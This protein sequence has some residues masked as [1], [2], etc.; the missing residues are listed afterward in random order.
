MG[1][2]YQ[3]CLVLKMTVRLSFL[4]YLSRRTL[5]HHLAS[6]RGLLLLTTLASTLTSTLAT[7]SSA[8]VGARAPSCSGPVKSSPSTYWLVEQDHIGNPRGYAPHDMF[9]AADAE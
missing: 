7:A 3:R 6:M 5:A 1:V 4:I 8:A 9:A 2:L